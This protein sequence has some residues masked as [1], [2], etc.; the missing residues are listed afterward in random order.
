MP[1]GLMKDITGQKF[2]ELTV[3]GYSHSDRK[4]GQT[5]WKCMCSCGKEHVVCKANLQNGHVTSCGHVFMAAVSKK[6]G[7]SQ[8]GRTL[9][10]YKHNAKVRN[11]PWELSKD[12][13]L[14]LT[15]LNCFYCGRPPSNVSSRKISTGDFIYSGIDR[16]DSSL[17]YVEGNVVPCCHD[18]SVA[19][20]GHSYQEFKSWIFQIS[21]HMMSKEAL[22]ANRKSS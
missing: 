19:K 17:R 5:Y 8:I 9:Y 14:R 22:Y 15:S 6:P 10:T 12:E 20:M 2:G 13:F 21:D 16:L 7:Q 1:H 3:L 4:A 11:L 18:C